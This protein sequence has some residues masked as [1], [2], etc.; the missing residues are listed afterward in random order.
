L[1]KCCFEALKEHL[2]GLHNNGKTMRPDP[3]GLTVMN[4]LRRTKAMVSSALHF[5][6]TK[7]LAPHPRQ[8]EGDAKLG[9][10]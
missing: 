7:H 5:G 8:V 6:T 2:V 10:P 4:R 1:F 3:A 9:L